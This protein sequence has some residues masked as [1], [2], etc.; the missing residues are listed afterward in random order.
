MGNRFIPWANFYHHCLNRFILS[1]ILLLF[2][3]FP[4][5]YN[6]D[7][8]ARLLGQDITHPWVF[9]IGIVMQGTKRVT[10]GTLPPR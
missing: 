9:E 5:I 2:V 1:I 6:T 7:F 8:V 3:I 4:L 10:E